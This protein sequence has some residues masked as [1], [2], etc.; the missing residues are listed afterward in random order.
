MASRRSLDA[1]EAR[2]VKRM[3]ITLRCDEL[4]AL[5]ARVRRA[6]AVLEAI[7]RGATHPELGA[8]LA[9]AETAA[10]WET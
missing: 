10:E 9:L 7:K 6:E 4:A 3:R 2:M 5:C 1:M 8:S